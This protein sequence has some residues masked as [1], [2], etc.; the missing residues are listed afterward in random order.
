MR[1]R[2]AAWIN[3]AL[4]LCTA[5]GRAVSQSLADIRSDRDCTIVSAGCTCW[6]VTRSRAIRRVRIVDSGAGWV[7][8]EG[9][10]VAFVAVG[11]WVQMGFASPQLPLSVTVTKAALMT[12][13]CQLSLSIPVKHRRDGK[14]PLH[15]AGVGPVAVAATRLY[16]TFIANL[17]NVIFKAEDAARVSTP[18]GCSMPDWSKHHSYAG[19]TS[20]ARQKPASNGAGVWLQRNGFDTAYNVRLRAMRA[21]DKQ[22]EAI[23]SISSRSTQSRPVPLCFLKCQSRQRIRDYASRT[24]RAPNSGPG[25]PVAIV[26]RE[27]AVS[28]IRHGRPQC[29]RGGKGREL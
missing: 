11:Q 19:L 23:M 9:S 25:S 3:N 1:T 17:L 2:S 16:E 13:G 27:E 18:V 8:A 21:I 20:Y 26:I 10:I 28:T 5:D 7:R 22:R 24:R 29:S 12:T 14:G 15:L 6:T 4:A